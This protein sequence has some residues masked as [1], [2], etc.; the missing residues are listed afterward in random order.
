MPTSPTTKKEMISALEASGTTDYEGTPLTKLSVDELQALLTAE[1][2]EGKERDPMAGLASL[3]R[4]ELEQVYNWLSGEFAP[5]GKE[6][7][8]RGELLLHIRRLLQTLP[9]T[10]V[11][12]GKAMKGRLMNEVLTDTFSSYRTWLWNEAKET[13]HPLLKQTCMFS[14]LHFDQIKHVPPQA[15]PAKPEPMQT[16][17][18]EE[19]DNLVHFKKENWTEVKREDLDQMP[20]RPQTKGRASPTTTPMTMTPPT[21]DGTTDFEVY[22]ARMKKWLE[23]VK[24]LGKPGMTDASKRP[25][26]QGEDEEL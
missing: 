25:V 22:E 10:Q 16:P 2:Q 3:S 4:A 8:S 21:Y 11:T 26:P 13:S 24:N 14:K 1:K 15:E 9:K 19:P 7:K 23:H 5:R 6:M 20:L 18:P 12:I 17:F